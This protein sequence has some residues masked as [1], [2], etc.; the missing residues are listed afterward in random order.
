M[1]YGRIR[2]R[3]YDINWQGPRSSKARSVWLGMASRRWHGSW[4]D[5]HAHH[6]DQLCSLVTGPCARWR[7][8][9]PSWHITCATAGCAKPFECVASVPLNS[10]CRWGCHPYSPLQ[11]YWWKVTWYHP[12]SSSKLLE[13]F[14][15]QWAWPS[16][17]K[18]LLLTLRRF[19]IHLYVLWGPCGRQT[20]DQYY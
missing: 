6:V 17:Q 15:K 20:L 1:Q 7:S 3:T 5:P 11:N 2:T 4:L 14:S 8:I 12:S 10:C 9:F 16:I 13:N 18:Y 19:S